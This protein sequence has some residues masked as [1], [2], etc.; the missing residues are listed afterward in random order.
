MGKVHKKEHFY[1]VLCGEVTISGAGKRERVKG[2]R[3]FV[4]SP[5][6]KRAV[7][8]HTDAVCMTVHRTDQTD[9]EKIEDELTEPDETSM[10]LPGNIAKKQELPCPS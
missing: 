4:S 9:I 2:P 6:T 10:Y 7:Y 1:V 8:A 5:G 3:I